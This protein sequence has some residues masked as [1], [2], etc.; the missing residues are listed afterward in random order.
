MPTK[1][2]LRENGRVLHYIF[3]EPWT[4]KDMEEAAAK[5]RTYYDAADRKLHVLFDA[6][7]ISSLPSG[8]LR[9]RNNPDMRHPNSGHIAVV[10][11]STVLQVIAETI[12][13][14]TRFQRARFFQSEDE[15]WAYLRRIIAEEEAN[16][17]RKGPA[18]DPDA[19]AD[20][21]V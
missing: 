11:A 12:L 7:A 20:D 18:S 8:L 19:P 10:G 5:A 6:R 16:R 21:R 13:R 2:E 4:L 3:T 17:G 14:I 1:V 15:A 9:A